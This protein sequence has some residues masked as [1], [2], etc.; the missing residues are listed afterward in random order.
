MNSKY[1]LIA[2][3][4]AVALGAGVANATPTV[5]Q[6]A[7]PNYSLV[8]AGS[9]A[10]AKSFAAAIQT[11]LCGGAANTLS[12]ASSSGSANF[13]AY[14]CVPATGTAAANA[15]GTYVNGS[16]I[17]TIYYRTEGGSVVGALPLVSGKQILRLNIAACTSAGVCTVS[18]VTSV[19]GPQDSWTGA[20][21]DDSVQLGVTDVEPGKLTGANYPSNYNSSVFG[22]A[23]ATQLANLTTKPLFDQVFGMFINTSGGVVTTTNLSKEAVANILTAKTAT[24][25]YTDWAEVPDAVSG[26]KMYTGTAAS[27]ITVIQREPGSGTRT[28]ANIYYLS[29]P[30]SSTTALYDNIPANDNYSTGDELNAANAKAGAIAYASIDNFYSNSSTG[31]SAGSNTKYPNLV[32]ATINGVFPSNLAAATGQYDEWFEAKLVPATLSGGSAAIATWIEADVSALATAPQ[33]ADINVIPGVSGNTPAFPLT[34]NGQT[35]TKEVYVNPFTRGGNSCAVPAE[36]Q[37]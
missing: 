5:A 32:L 4:V 19:N 36:A 3:A 35:G 26:A 15:I 23:T 14:S 29:Y 13:L 20:V 30:C 31:T 1:P 10:A 6:A 12:L 9:S 16:N 25:G 28:Q 27:P 17:F 8:I 22:S 18:G 33:V 37:F 7:A 34:N 24:S 11:D 21:V 2:A